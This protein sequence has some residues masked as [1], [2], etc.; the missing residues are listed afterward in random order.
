MKVDGSP[1]QFR[2]N[3][4]TTHTPKSEVVDGQGQKKDTYVKIS[5][6][7]REKVIKKNSPDDPL[8]SKKILDSLDVGMIQFSQKERDT[9]A[10]VLGAEAERVREQYIDQAKEN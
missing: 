3:K 1:P 7:P 10:K 4:S 2:I 9:L 8:V 6:R 5:F